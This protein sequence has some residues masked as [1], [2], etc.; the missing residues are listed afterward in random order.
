VFGFKFRP[1]AGDGQALVVRL[2]AQCAQ[3]ELGSAGVGGGVV[4][5]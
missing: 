3:V 4:L 1:Q 2:V 5:Q